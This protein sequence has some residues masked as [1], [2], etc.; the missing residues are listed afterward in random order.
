[1]VFSSFWRLSCFNSGDLDT[2]L[3]YRRLE[4]RP[5]S[6]TLLLILEF[7]Q[8]DGRLA[9]LN[10]TARA[11]VLDKIAGLVELQTCAA[12][13]FRTLFVHHLLQGLQLEAQLTHRLGLFTFDLL[14]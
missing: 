5:F 10:L 12:T 11:N 6:E 8:G 4:A 14:S 13:E 1:M 2:S 7:L 3:L 9:A